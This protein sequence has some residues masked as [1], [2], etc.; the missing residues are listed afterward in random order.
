MAW[1]V[2]EPRKES[3]QAVTLNGHVVKTPSKHVNVCIPT[4]CCCQPW[5]EKHLSMVMHLIQWW[6]E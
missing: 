6:F 1:E 4:D 3:I 2:I 5:S